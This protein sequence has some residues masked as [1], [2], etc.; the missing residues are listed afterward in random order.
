MVGPRIAYSPHPNT[1]VEAE[2]NALS[3]IYQRAIECYEENQKAAGTSG[4]EDARKEDPNASG[5][6]IIPKRQ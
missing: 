4:G 1:T 6:T 5:K 3:A 2:L